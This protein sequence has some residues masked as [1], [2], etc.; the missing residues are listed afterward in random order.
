M[1][2]M[3]QAVKWP[4]QYEINLWAGNTSMITQI[5]QL[6]GCTNAVRVGLVLGWG[7]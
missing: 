6:H 3:G 4:D 2:R 1:L 5:S 7:H